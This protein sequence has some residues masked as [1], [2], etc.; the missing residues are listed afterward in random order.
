M[1]YKTGGSAVVVCAMKEVQV[2]EW[3]GTFFS[4]FQSTA[5]FQFKW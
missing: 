5:L 2:L 3:L 1:K 4:A